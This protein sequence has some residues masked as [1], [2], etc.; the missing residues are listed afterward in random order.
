MKSSLFLSHFF[1][2]TKKNQKKDN[3]KHQYSNIQVLEFRQRVF[4]RFILMIKWVDGLS[5]RTRSSTARSVRSLVE[6]EEI[7]WEII[8]TNI[9]TQLNILIIEE[10]IGKI[11]LRI[12]QKLENRSQTHAIPERRFGWLQNHQLQKPGHQDFH[13]SQPLERIV[14]VCPHTTIFQTTDFAIAI[15]S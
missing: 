13:I 2:Y 5:M 3:V 14:Y 12:V 8:T 15:G 9:V 4:K 11:L 7:P 10:W 6:D 1:T